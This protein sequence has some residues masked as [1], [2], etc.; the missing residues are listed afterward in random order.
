VRDE[1]VDVQRVTDAAGEAAA[2]YAKAHGAT[3][4]RAALVV[5]CSRPAAARAWSRLY[6]TE[7]R[8]Q[9]Q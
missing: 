1:E 3:L 8:R 2:R 7:E 6:P 9:V 5:G 4:T